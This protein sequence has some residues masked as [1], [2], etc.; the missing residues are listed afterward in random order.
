MKPAVL[1]LAGSLFANAALIGLLV[2]HGAPGSSSTRSGETTTAGALQTDPS[3]ARDE[4]ASAPTPEAWTAL[5]ADG[6][7]ALISRLRAAGFPPHVLRA[8]A[9]QRVRAELADARRALYRSAV[10]PEYW[11]RGYMF[12]PHGDPAFRSGQRDILE[13]EKARLKELL[14]PDYQPPHLPQEFLA[15]L[16]RR[17]GNLPSETLEQV[18]RIESDYGELRSQVMNNAYGIRL[19]ED[20]KMLQHLNEEMRSDLAALL[21]PEQLE[22][23]DLRSSTT[24]QQLRSRLSA[25][26]LTEEEYRDVYRLQKAFDDAYA[27]N[28]GGV[29]MGMNMV[30]MGTPSA[31]A[32]TVA[33]SP[34]QREAA[35]ARLREE[36]VALLG[37]ERVAAMERANDF[38]YRAMETIANRLQLPNQVVVQAYS[39]QKDIQQRASAIRGDRTL[40]PEQR[41]ARLR[42]LQ[43][44]AAQKLGNL[45]TPR[46]LDAYKINGGQ[47]I[48]TLTP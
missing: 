48:N 23:Y 17:Y 45:L 32:S 33:V 16:S 12:G 14:G 40:T 36:M 37:E 42:T 19:P 25:I 15:N 22:A 34:E 5:S 30:V 20:E 11:K 46:G 44:E 24:A 47:W 28:S 27:P 13:Q 9:L 18:Q 3:A 7:P 41:S 6:T 10:R 4:A 2:L 38:S 31:T 8:V 29:V 1:L 35:Q 21:G 26:D 39:V 43:Q